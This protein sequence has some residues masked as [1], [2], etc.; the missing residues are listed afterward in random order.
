MDG[1][2]PP[3]L[4]TRRYGEKLKTVGTTTTNYVTDANDREVP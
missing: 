4:M 2:S 1:L 3:T